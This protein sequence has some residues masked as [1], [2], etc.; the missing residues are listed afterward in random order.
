MKKLMA[1]TIFAS[2]ILTMSCGLDDMAGYIKDQIPEED[3]LVEISLEQVTLTSQDVPEVDIADQKKWAQQVNRLGAQL[4]AQNY[5]ANENIVFSPA[6]LHS[7]MSMAAYGAE[8][9]TYKEIAETLTFEDERDKASRLS[10]AMQLRL[11]YDGQNKNSHFVM[12]N[13]L[14]FDSNIELS[15]RFKKDME[16]KFRAPVQICN[17]LEYTFEVLDAIYDWMKELTHGWMNPV[18]NDLEDPQFVLVNATSF[19][20]KW[21][22]PFD[23]RK[24]E[25][26]IFNGSTQNTLIEFMHLVYDFK[27][28]ENAE[29]GYQAVVI[30][31]MDGVFDMVFVLPHDLASAQNV[32]QGINADDLGTILV[33]AADTQLVELSLPKF[34][35]SYDIVP[36]DLVSRLKNIGIQEAFVEGF[37]NFDI[38]SPSYSVFIDGIL[39]QAVIKISEGGTNVDAESSIT[40]D[41]VDESK[42]IVPF[43][44]DHAF[45]FALVHRA[46]GAVV[47][48]GLMNDLG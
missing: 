13:N 10:A 12:A 35:I 21:E 37:A 39:H 7:A 32:L 40:P 36:E 46:T 31:Y 43:H 38:L 42:T 44:V 28:Y 3:Y 33:E 47:Y 24:T 8:G 45:A 16:S 26:K 17:F 9:T 25:Q 20:G 48:L 6:A 30:P 14:W 18:W 19:Q 22:F 5:K 23:S 34:N 29:E 1:A 15:E 27:Y 2:S 11:R 4:I 41:K